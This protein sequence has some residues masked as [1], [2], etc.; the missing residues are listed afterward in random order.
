AI[1]TEHRAASL[2]GVAALARQAPT[3]CWLFL[4]AG[5]WAGWRLAYPTYNLWEPA[6]RRLPALRRQQ[7]QALRPPNRGHTFSTTSFRLRQPSSG[8]VPPINGCSITRR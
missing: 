2:L 4:R 7:R 8:G 6:C 3:G 5:R 1:V